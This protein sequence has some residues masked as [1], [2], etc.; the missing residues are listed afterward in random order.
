MTLTPEQAARL[1]DA[2]TAAWNTGEPDA[3][4]SFFTPDGTIII[5][6]GEPS[7][8]RAGAAAMA[9]GF[10][11]DIPDLQLTSGG[12]RCAGDHVLYLWSFTGTHVET[13]NR[14]HVSG[15]EEW[16]LAEDHLVRFSRGWFDADDY[17]R[18][19]AGA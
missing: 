14:L 13:G 8:G 1:A 17:A 15:W 2:Y 7:V 3:V 11:A 6:N 19:I 4:A 12:A 16:D 5:N 9:A 18:Q 10:Y